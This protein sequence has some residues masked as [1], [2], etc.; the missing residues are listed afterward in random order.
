[1]EPLGTPVLTEYCCEDVPSRTTQSHLLLR[2]E[3]LSQISNLKKTSMQKP[4]K[5]LGYTSATAQ[6]TPELF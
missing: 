6:V 4:V 2:K 3:E 1:M 5:S